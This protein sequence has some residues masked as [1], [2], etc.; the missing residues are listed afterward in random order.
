MAAENPLDPAP[1]KV[2]AAGHAAIELMADYLGGIQDRPVYP[3]VTSKGIREQLD[4]ELPQESQ[5]LEEVLAVFRDVLVPNSRQNAH[6]R[7]FGYVQ[8]PGTAVAAIADL[9][10]STLNANLT[11]WRFR[12][13]RRG[14]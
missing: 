2:R 9:L 10:A 4:P 7:M 5:P 11:A 12:A 3:D 1:D 8:A 13:G 14:A 6:P